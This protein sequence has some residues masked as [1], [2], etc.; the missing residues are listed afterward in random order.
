LTNERNNLKITEVKVNI[1]SWLTISSLIVKFKKAAG[2]EGALVQ[3]AR[4]KSLIK[5]AVLPP[6]VI[7]GPSDGRTESINTRFSDPK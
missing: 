4:M 5:K 7:R 1:N 6:V 2:L 3:L